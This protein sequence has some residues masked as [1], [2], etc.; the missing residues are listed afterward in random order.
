MPKYTNTSK[1]CVNCKIRLQESG[2]EILKSIESDRVYTAL[3]S[4]LKELFGVDFWF[5]FYETSI[6]F[7]SK[8]DPT[9]SYDP[10]ESL[11]ERAMNG[12]E[13]SEEEQTLF[14]KIMEGMEGER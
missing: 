11:I 13:L 12:E 8:F 6:G 7:C 1:N 4:A 9:T 5:S 2:C 10:T 3:S 14:E